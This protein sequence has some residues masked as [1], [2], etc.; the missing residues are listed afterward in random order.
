[1]PLPD[2]RAC[3][4]ADRSCRWQRQPCFPRACDFLHGLLHVEARQQ[5]ELLP[6]VLRECLYCTQGV[7]S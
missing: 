1:M 2:A 3:R 5:L 4:V 6:G 7:G